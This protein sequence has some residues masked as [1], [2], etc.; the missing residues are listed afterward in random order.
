MA[1][2][3]IALTPE[4]D[5]GRRK[6]GRPKRATRE[7]TSPNRRRTQIRLAQRAYRS[8]R[9]TEMQALR[10]RVDELES[11]LEQMNE[12]FLSFTDDLIKSGALSTRPAVARRLHQTI[13]QSLSLTNEAVL[14]AD[15]A[16]PSTAEINALETTAPA[17]D[18]CEAGNVPI[19]DSQRE[20]SIH[21]TSS[22]APRYAFAVPDVPAQVTSLYPSPLFLNS[23]P[24]STSSLE[25]VSFADRLYRA[26]IEQGHHCL[27]NPSSQLEELMYKFRLPL[28]V[29]PLHN[30]RAHFEE[31]LNGG[32]H[33]A[34]VAM[35]IPFISI[36]GAGTHFKHSQR[37]YAVEDAWFQ[38]SMMQ[39]TTGRVDS[40]MRG[41]W[42]DCYDV[43]GYL[44]NCGIVPVRSLAGGR[45]IPQQMGN[46]KIIDE[47]ILIQ[48]LRVSCVCLGRAPGFPRGIVE[49]F[50][51]QHSIGCSS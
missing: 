8:R 1:E 42:F 43:E 16:N 47:T 14:V 21:Y 15:D 50:A 20:D 2:A 31:F 24:Y 39:A 46:K 40:D 7:D 30:I 12:T 11:L 25:S 6:R 9:E 36:G 33:G 34:L 26:C 23:Q 18:T 35:S 38:P 28:T 32:Y 45:S 5:T 4:D 19:A 22:V 41:D 10:T 3:R 48:L 51:T 44:D 49:S 37:S 13:A 27:T 17:N 29:L